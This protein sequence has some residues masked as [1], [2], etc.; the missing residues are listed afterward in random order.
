V[1]LNKRWLHCRWLEKTFRQVHANQSSPSMSSSVLPLLQVQL[2]RYGLPLIL[3][4][5]NI[6]NVFITVLFS[7]RRRNSCSIYLWW[8]AVMNSAFI[9]FNIP[10]S[11]YSTEYRN[12][13]LDSL[14]FCKI[15]LYLSHA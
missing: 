14:A 15:R 8:A 12:P 6:G 1:K 2:N 11:L 10:V 3:I 9:T 4:L 7:Q 5:G 13:T